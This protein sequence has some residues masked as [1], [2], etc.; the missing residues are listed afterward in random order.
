M[1]NGNLHMKE[2]RRRKRKDKRKKSEY[3]RM[4]EG[5]RVRRASE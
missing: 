5:V 2:V 3:E 1:R 4:G